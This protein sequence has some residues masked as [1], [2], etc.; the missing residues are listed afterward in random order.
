MVSRRSDA[1]RLEDRAR[2]ED[3]LRL[4]PLTLRQAHVTL[5]PL[6]YGFFTLAKWMVEQRSLI[7]PR[8]S[9]LSAR[10]KIVWGLEALSQTQTLP[11]CVRGGRAAYVPL[12]ATAQTLLVSTTRTF[13]GAH[14]AL[15]VA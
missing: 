10:L 1:Q 11:S 7:S 15:E 14:A 6:F 13:S 2:K 4:G 9:Q 8:T 3:L 12:I 5:L